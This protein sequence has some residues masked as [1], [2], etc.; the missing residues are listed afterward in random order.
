VKI[1][2]VSMYLLVAT[3]FPV[4]S[5]K[6]WFRIQVTNNATNF[7]DRNNGL[8]KMLPG[9]DIPFSW[10]PLPRNL[11]PGSPPDVPFN[12]REGPWDY[13]PTEGGLVFK[14]DT[15]DPNKR[16]NQVMVFLH[17]PWNFLDLCSST[18]YKGQGAVGDAARN[19]PG[20]SRDFVWVMGPGLGLPGPAPPPHTVVGAGTTG[21][22]AIRH[23]PVPKYRHYFCPDLICPDPEAR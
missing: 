13:F 1:K 6:R 7:R 2:E 4:S 5:P 21:D 9:G 12:T 3:I 17:V 22:P 15:D 8:Y 19:F 16:P 11:P 18:P 10:A 14:V 23:V 20:P